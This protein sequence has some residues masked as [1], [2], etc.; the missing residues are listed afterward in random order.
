MHQSADLAASARQLLEQQKCDWALA[1]DNFAAIA[2]VQ[3]RAIGL[4]GFT[5][6]LQFN[7]TRIVS[8]GSKIDPKAIAQRPC[9]LCN[10]N[11]PR[12]QASIPFGD[13]YLLLVNPF[14]IF[15][16]HFTI[17]NNQHVMQRIRGAFPALLELAQAVSPRYTAFYNGPRAG[18]SAP[19]HLHFQ[20]GDRGFMTI[21]SEIARLKGRP[22]IERGGAKVYAVPSLRPFIVIESAD[23]EASVAAFD[24]IYQALAEVA[25]ADDEPSMNVLAFR[26][27]G[28]FKT[29]I[30]PRAKHRPDFYYAEG[31]AKIMISPGTVDLGGVVILPVEKDYHRITIDHLRQMLTEVMLPAEKFQRAC[32]LLT[33]SLS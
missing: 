2:R 13:D 11:R 22:I 18:A 21:E 3:T 10:A 30:L 7:P 25:P 23:A 6:R 12:E 28:E 27:D 8:T 14:P 5:M 19:D 4:D 29:I 32:E 9:F 17:T 24:A 20:A 15:P 33:Q 16:E 1:R 26:D 31:D